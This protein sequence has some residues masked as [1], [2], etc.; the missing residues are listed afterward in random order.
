MKPATFNFR[1]PLSLDRRLD[2]SI[3]GTLF[4][5]TLRQHLRGRRLLLLCFFFCL[6]ALVAILAQ[7]YGSTLSPQELEFTLVFTL[8]PHALVPLA[9]L[10]YA[11]GMIQDEIE[12]QT[13]TYLLVRPLP[14]WA[15]YAT[16]LLATYLLTAVLTGFFVVVTYIAIYVGQPGDWGN[17]LLARALPVAALLALALVAYCA[18]FGWLGLY[19]RW[20]LVVGIIYIIVFEGILANIDF[21]VRRLTVMYYFRVLS[22]RWLELKKTGWAL[23]LS[24]APSASACV[25]TLLGVGVAATMLAALAFS[26]REFR[27]KTP[28]GS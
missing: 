27:V 22:E 12:E 24:T 11:S 2:L 4:L 3:P 5:L 15:L 19:T 10:L 20:A 1:A 9:A 17:V 18:L 14:R 23:D 28:E 6:P 13:L 16:K 21:A 25:W 7:A 26:G 8:L